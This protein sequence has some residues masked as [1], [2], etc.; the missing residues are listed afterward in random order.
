AVLAPAAAY[1]FRLR[2]RLAAFARARRLC[3]LVAGRRAPVASASWASPA[4]ATLRAS[5]K[6]T[7][8]I[9]TSSTIAT[10]VASTIRVPVFELEFDSVEA[11]VAVVWVGVVSR[12]ALLLSV[13]I[14]PSSRLA[15]G[16]AGAVAS[17]SNKHAPSAAASFRG[18]GRRRRPTPRG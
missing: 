3:S 2:W 15:A 14:A 12:W 13:L 8:P 5:R 18:V 11:V 16:A 6:I 7:Y 9:P 17:A 10:P 1:R 4:G